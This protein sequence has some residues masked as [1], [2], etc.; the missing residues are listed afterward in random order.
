MDEPIPISLVGPED[1]LET[2]RLALEPLRATHAA[3]LYDGLR[4][5]RLYRYIPTEPPASLEALR[6][7][8]ARLE[9]RRS[10]DGLE[11]WLNWAVRLRGAEEYVGTLE[12]S[13]HPDGV[14]DVAYLVFTPR[15][16][17]GYAREGL[18]R[19][20]QLLFDCYG[21]RCVAAEID[22]RNAASIA[23]V[24][25]LGFARVATRRGADHFKGEPSDEYRY[26][27][28]RARPQG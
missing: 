22:T 28:R 10:P 7:R 15:Q 3:A 21:A 26:E 18:A 14:A 5:D 1:V 12:A 9:S 24:E 23:L 20:L 25:S 11:A 16:G 13:V 17:C 8:Y 6:G 4:D 19:L 2:E 27:L